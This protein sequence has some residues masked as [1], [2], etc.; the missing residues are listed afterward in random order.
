V[1]I[2]S[3]AVLDVDG[4]AVVFVRVGPELYARREVLLG[5]R[6]GDRVEVRAGLLAGERVA[7]ASLLSLKNA[8]PAPQAPAR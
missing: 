7:I 1:V 8:A 2:P 6:Q 5:R 4:R 3:A